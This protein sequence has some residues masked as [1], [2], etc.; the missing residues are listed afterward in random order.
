MVVVMALVAGSAHAA[1]G[2]QSPPA[3][4]ADQPALMREGEALF[5]SACVSCHADPGMES[6]GPTLGGN[7]ALTNKDHVIR[8]VLQG[9]PEKGMPPFAPSYS[10]RQVAAVATFI[11]NA[12]DNAYG[13]V[14]EADVA[15]IR[16]ELAKK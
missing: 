7:A 13:V 2:R 3:D 11:R 8:R 16:D 6:I 15:R 12:W 14:T 4:E 9:V 1:A 10:N 5:G